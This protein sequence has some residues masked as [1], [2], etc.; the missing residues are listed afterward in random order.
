MNQSEAVV[1]GMIDAVS[2]GNIDGMLSRMA[3]SV[4][5]VEPDSLAYG[6]AH[7][8]VDAFVK[9]V[10]GVMFAKAEFGASNH[11]YLSAG[12]TVAVSMLATIT[13]RKTGKVL[14]MPYMELYTVRDGLVTR[15][16]VYPQ[17][18]KT[19]VEFWDAN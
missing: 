19:L 17:D 15:I 9:D 11:K 16:E 7:R 18:T 2:A 8:G 6:G 13:S 10:I 12:D 14:Q 4:E 1:R 5:V 3:P